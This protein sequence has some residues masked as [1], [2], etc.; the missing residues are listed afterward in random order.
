MPKQPVIPGLRGAV[1]KTVTRRQQF[2]AEMDAVRLRLR[3]GW[4]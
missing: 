4:F 2:R 3:D 1:K